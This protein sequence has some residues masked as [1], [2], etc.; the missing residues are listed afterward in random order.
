MSLLDD[1][2]IDER[3][4]V[5]RDLALCKGVDNR[6]F[7]DWYEDDKEIARQ[8]D[9]M[10]LSCPVFHECQPVGMDGNYG[11]W[12]GVYWNGAARPDVN[13]NGHKSQFTW[14]RIRTRTLE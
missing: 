11:V 14:D 9:E 12:A 4:F 10:C 8:V 3:D 7:F 2:G 6:Y 13:K 1:L 5:W